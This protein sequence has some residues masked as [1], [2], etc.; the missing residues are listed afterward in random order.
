MAECEHLE[1]TSAYFDG[2][3]EASEEAA[4]V[5]HLAGCAECQALL[6]D[7]VALHA[8]LSDAPRVVPARTRSRRWPLVA[9]ATTALAA[10]SVA[11]VVWPREK[12][13]PVD[14]VAIELPSQ[15]ASEARFTGPRFAPYRPRAVVRSDQ[16]PVES[17]SLASLSRL[18]QAGEQHDLIAALAATGDLRRA[19]QLV[20]ALPDDARTSSDRSALALSAGDAEAALAHAQHALGLDSKLAAARWNLGLAADRLGLPYVARGAFTELDVLHEPGWSDESRER[21]RAREADTTV[22]EGFAA[23]LARGT[24]MVDG[25]T[26]LTATDVERYPAQTRINFYDA[27][28]VAV[29]R[30]RLEALRPLAA[31]LD[32]GTGATFA[33]D[34]LGRSDPA[35]TA[36]YAAAYR[37]V[38]AQTAAAA[39][40]SRLIDQLRAEGRAGDLL[41]LGTII[42]SSQV[43]S[44]LEEVRAIVKPWNDPWFTLLLDREELRA[45]YGATDQRAAAPLADVL[46]RCSGLHV[47][48]RCG[49]IAADL[50]ELALARDDM[51]A[52]EAFA[53]KSV[54]HYRAAMMPVQLG[55]Q[56][57][58]VAE[59]HRL[60]GRTALARAELEDM[61]LAS[62]DRDCAGVRY[63]RITQAELAIVDGEWGAARAALPPASVPAECGQGVDILGI[64]AAVD[65]ARATRS[66]EDRAVA[67]AW[68]AHAGTL[69][70]GGIAT[71]GAF[72]AGKGTAAATTEWVSGHAKSRDQDVAA[73]RAWGIATLVDDAGEREA[74]DEVIRTA[75]VPDT[76]CGVVASVDDDRITV[77]VRTSAG[78]FGE[79]RRVPVRAQATTPVMSPALVAK[80]AACT[81][82]AV[83][84]RPPL[85]GRF[86]L[87]PA[88]LPWWFAGDS[89][90]RIAGTAAPRSVVVADAHPPDPGLPPVG[91]GSPAMPYDVQVTGTSAT[92]SKV[93]AALRDATYAQLDVHGVSIAM[94]PEAAYLALS[95]DPDGRYEL[96]ADAVAATKLRGA[97]VIVLAACRAASVAPYLRQRWSLPDAFV[98]AG[99]QAVVAVDVTIPDADAHIVFDVLRRRVATGVPVATAVAALRASAAAPWVKHLMVFR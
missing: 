10:A 82:I 93:L 11:L 80:L 90:P 41:R 99:A 43:A 64:A 26:P 56:R 24:A 27:V 23:F 87:L 77:A 75:Q 15:R 42:M 73:A 62:G 45:L 28:R 78:L 5:Q 22:E 2:A 39:E 25:G 70:E 19:N 72:R 31:A 21:R 88:E 92:P 58:L 89:A 13:N 17:I 47:E 98:S 12:A 63:A 36:K 61:I 52:A 57:A 91:F 33:Q 65:I 32:A 49:Q 6:G 54:A 37:A 8:A 96:R 66:A 55:R 44:R 83:V 51:S 50:A 60:Q 68:L 16:Q 34:A 94:R 86:D 9:I 53:R 14:A 67:D 84:A 79:H 20:S 29:D 38:F 18:E 81:D 95:P 3:L 69:A 40:A 30:P 4:A 7:A 35:I 1:R 85:H 74:W 76:A 48:Y 97:P 46:A 59:L 71:I